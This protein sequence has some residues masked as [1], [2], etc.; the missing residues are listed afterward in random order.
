MLGISSVYLNPTKNIIKS[1]QGQQKD[2]WHVE[3]LGED[4]KTKNASDFSRKTIEKKQLHQLRQLF[5]TSFFGCHIF[6]FFQDDENIYTTAGC[7]QT[8]IICT[9]EPQNEG[10]QALLTSYNNIIYI[11]TLGLSP[12]S[13]NGQPLDFSGLDFFFS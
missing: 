8:Y 11:N 12:H 4:V 6:A 2:F 13:A 9:F 7:F 1:R 3:A 10:V 5:F